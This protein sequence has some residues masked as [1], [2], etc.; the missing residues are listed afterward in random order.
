MLKNKGKIKVLLML[1]A[2]V[3]VLMI[4]LL[5]A[6]DVTKSKHIRSCLDQ[7]GNELCQEM[8]Y[9]FVVTL[10]L[11]ISGKGSFMCKVDIRKPN[12]R[13]YFT[14]TELKKC[15]NYRRFYANKS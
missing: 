8:G 7:K 9:S 5:L 15:K 10:P 6:Y 12:E 3:F 11:D 13:F 1:I 2:F 14:E 4:G